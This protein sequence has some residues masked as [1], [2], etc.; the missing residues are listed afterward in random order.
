MNIDSPLPFVLLGVLLL[1]GLAFT[2][3]FVILV[4]K[5]AQRS[6]SKQQE[7]AEGAEFLEPPS[8][9]TRLAEIEDAYQQGLITEEERAEARRAALAQA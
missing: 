2:V 7:L 3:G 9:A 6:A 8:L 4:I 5:L 1:L